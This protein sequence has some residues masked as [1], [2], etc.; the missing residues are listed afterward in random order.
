MNTFKS[1]LCVLTLALVWPAPQKALVLSQETADDMVFV[2]GFAGAVAPLLPMLSGSV[3]IPVSGLAFDNFMGSCMRAGALGVSFISSAG[4]ASVARFVLER[5]TPCGILEWAQKEL[6]RVESLN[7]RAVKPGP[8]YLYWTR[9]IAN[10]RLS[11]IRYYLC[12]LYD[13]V[14]YNALALDDTVLAT[15]KDLQA[16]FLLAAKLKMLFDKLNTLDPQG[17]QV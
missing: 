16:K 12:E 15:D 13:Y 4:S 8:S 7:A 14:E 1:I 9:E 3:A 11:Y 2:A 17:A 5:Y 10:L 6:D